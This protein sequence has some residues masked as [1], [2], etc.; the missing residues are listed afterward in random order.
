[1]VT[2]TYFDRPW[3]F[4]GNVRNSG[5]TDDYDNISN[6][7]KEIELPPFNRVSRRS[8]RSCKSEKSAKSTKASLH[9]PLDLSKVSR[10]F[11]A[12]DHKVP[13]VIPQLGPT[14]PWG[15]NETLPANFINQISMSYML[16]P[17]YHYQDW[18]RLL[19]FEWACTVYTTKYV[20]VA[21]N[22]C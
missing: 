11:R 10:Y 5:C 13:H 6:D 1:M 20:K 4:P 19:D 8:K 16:H 18:W 15:R 3:Y 14:A 12:R 21:K 22:G 7:S 9:L 17:M 2:L